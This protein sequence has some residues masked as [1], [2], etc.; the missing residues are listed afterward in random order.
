MHKALA[1]RPGDDVAVAVVPITAGEEI[2]VA[3][4]DTDAEEK[5]TTLT[6][7]PYGHKVAVHDRTAGDPVVEYGTQIGIAATDIVSGDYV[8]T[9]NLKS[10]R[11]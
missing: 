6:D 3:Y 7:I 10:A 5:I 1:H 11:W 2:I 9:H 4:L 8:H